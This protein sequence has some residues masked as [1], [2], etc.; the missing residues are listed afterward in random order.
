MK[1]RPFHRLTALLRRSRFAH[2]VHFARFVRA[3]PLVSIALPCTIPWALAP[4]AKAAEE[5]TPLPPPAANSPEALLSALSRCSK[6]DW[7]A[8]FRPPAPADLKSRPQIALIL[9]GVVADGY[10]AAQAEE[11]QQCRNTSKDLVMLAKSLG[12]QVEILDRSRSL[13]DS[14]QTRNWAVYKKELAAVG[15]DL[16]KV[17]KKHGD[18]DLAH[19]VAIGTWLR[20]TEIIVSL[21]DQ[22]YSE[23]A[24]ALL[25]QPSI[26]HFMESEVDAVWK[27][28]RS[29][30]SVEL[31]RSRLPA[32]EQVLNGSSDTAPS[33]DEIHTLAGA[34]T[35]LLQ[36]LLV[37]RG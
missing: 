32:M 28:L 6:P 11:P 35:S 31:I 30:P 16:E 29:E 8:K 25:R 21:L 14:A 17:L 24:A 10:L 12:V 37:R 7:A 15:G 3:L 19:L 5:T 36:E 18:E 4:C 33:K 9:G 26:G 2:L 34:L 13:A 1:P 27:K 22:S 20:M 23:N